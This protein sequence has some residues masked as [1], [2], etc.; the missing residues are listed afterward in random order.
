MRGKKGANVLTEQVIFLVL[1][2]LF[3]SVLLAFL[4]FQGAGKIIL[5]KN[6]AKQIALLIDS[7]A[8]DSEIVLDLSALAKKKDSSF[9]W[10][11]VVQISGNS[12]MVTLDGK[13]KGEYSF[14]KKVSARADPQLDN[15]F[16]I[17]IQELS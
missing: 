7:S 3:L 17:I 2:V 8:P 5:E 13:S 11:R 1:N 10:D 14:F 12:V 15:K 6:T 9:S 4:Y 16:K